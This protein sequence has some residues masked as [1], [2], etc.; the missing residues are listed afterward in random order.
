M[1]NTVEITVTADTSRFKKDMSAASEQ[2][3][4]LR[5][6][7]GS[8]GDQIS[9]DAARF[10]TASER[11]STALRRQAD[12]TSNARLAI[13]RLTKAR[14][15]LSRL[16]DDSSKRAQAMEREAAAVRNAERALIRLG[17]ARQNVSRAEAGGGN[18]FINSILGG[19]PGIGAIAGGVGLGTVAGGLALQGINLAAQYGQESLQFA[20]NRQAAQ[21]SLNAAARSGGRS[22]LLATLNAQSLA[23]DLG[24]TG[25]VARNLQASG[26]RYSRFIGRRD[27]GDFIRALSD[28]NAANGNQASTEVIASQIFRG[29][30]EGFDKLGL[31]AYN[32]YYAEFAKQSGTTVDKLDDVT[33]AEI[34]YQAVLKAGQEVKGESIRFLETDIGKLQQ[35]SN[36]LDETKTRTGAVL[37]SILADIVRNPVGDILAPA[38]S[39]PGRAAQALGSSLGGFL[40]GGSRLRA[41][42]QADALLAAATQ[43]RVAA[44]VRDRRGYQSTVNYQSGGLYGISSDATA[45]GRAAFDKKRVDD[46]REAIA[47]A[48]QELLQWSAQ[49]QAANQ[50]QI[51]T[52]K[53]LGDQISQLRIQFTGDA[54]PFLTGARQGVLGIQ[55]L[56]RQL[57]PRSA[58]YSRDNIGAINTAIAEQ[59]RNISLGLAHSLAAEAVGISG[60]DSRL[61]SLRALD[62]NPYDLFNQQKKD[63]YRYQYGIGQEQFQQIEDIFSSSNKIAREISQGLDSS[64]FTG[65]QKESI[66]SKIANETLIQRLGSVDPSTLSRSQ[67]QRYEQELEKYRAEQIRQEV[68]TLAY[69][70]KIADKDALATLVVKADKGTAITSSST[71]QSG[72]GDTYGNAPSPRY[73]NGTAGG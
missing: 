54:N 49:Q 36:Q 55:A 7:L 11:V 52:F 47:K 41:N 68:E 66:A 56:Q 69:L 5:K 15:V 72:G 42:E 65:A 51:A 12:A 24:L 63:V 60:T 13:E 3:V 31:R 2:I 25:T 10:S 59:Q 34:R 46:Y 1:A 19:I 17:Q 73:P 33:K 35:F 37:T 61:A 30:D 43:E 70:K 40:T 57:D 38:F 62:K 32:S 64:L 53:Q 20:A 45:E 44:A 21:F 18:S 16:P 27:E 4:R 39:L 6:E 23:S 29:E 14:E 50:S 8:A 9:R 71:A 26:L 28:L 67:R 58:G 22:P 48:N